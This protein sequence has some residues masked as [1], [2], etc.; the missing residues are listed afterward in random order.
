MEAMKLESIA[1]D[2][3]IEELKVVGKPLPP[4]AALLDDKD[5]G[6]GKNK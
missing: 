4:A 6:N 3:E 5:K 1:K 2:R